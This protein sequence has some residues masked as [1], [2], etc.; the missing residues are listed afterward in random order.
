M[1]SFR[2]ILSLILV[3]VMTLLVSCAAPSA[4]KAPTTYTAEKIE[5]IQTLLAPVQAA[6]EQMSELESLIEDE[7]WVDT[8]TFIH[9]PLG[10]LRQEMTYLSRDL[11]PQDQKKASQLAKKLFIDFERLD[12]AAKDRDYGTAVSQY[13]EALKDFDAFLELIPSA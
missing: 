10:L 2:S 3:L 1:A 7:K 8:D 11:L 9:G 13:R 6:R 12:A 4:T 5:Q